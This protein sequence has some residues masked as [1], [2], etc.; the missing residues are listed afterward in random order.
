MHQSEIKELREKLEHS[1]SVIAR[2]QHASTE[3]SA[4]GRL[5]EEISMIGKMV[6]EERLNDQRMIRARSV[7]EME[8]FKDLEREKGELGRKLQDVKVAMD[9]YSERLRNKVRELD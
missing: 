5:Q 1:G 7:E 6:M 4:V 9:G 8:T 2:L 3:S